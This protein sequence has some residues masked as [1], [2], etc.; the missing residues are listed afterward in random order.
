[1]Q[2][3]TETPSTTASVKHG[4][5]FS[6]CRISLFVDSSFGKPSLPWRYDDDF[7]A[8]INSGSLSSQGSSRCF[9]SQVIVVHLFDVLDEREVSIKTSSKSFIL[10]ERGPLSVDG[11]RQGR[12]QWRR[13]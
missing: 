5:V 11:G 4:P 7:A 8:R 12:S 3:E 13:K 1:M 10:S 6:Y 2:L 9:H